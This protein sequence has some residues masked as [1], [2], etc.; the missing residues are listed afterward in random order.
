MTENDLLNKEIN[1]WACT[2]L[3]SLGYTLESD[4]PDIVLNTPWSYVVRFETSEA[5]L[6]LKHTPEPLALE[7][8]IIQ[9][10]RDQF[11]ASVPTVIA[12]NAKLNCFL[13]KDAGRP[14]R[15]LLKQQFDA[16]LL[17]KA[18]DQFTAMQFAVAERVYVFLDI[19]VPDWR[20][21]QLPDLYMEMLSQKD[22]LMADGISEI[23]IRP[24]EALHPQVSTLC[25]KLSDYGLKQTIIQPDFHDNNLLI[26]DVSQKITII[27]LGEV[28]V[29]HPFFS[30]I[31][32]LQQIKKHH[33][34]TDDDEAYLKIKEACMKSYSQF[35]LAG[36]LSIAQPLWHVYSI[37]S[38]TRLMNACGKDN[39][40]SIQPGRLS[41]SLKALRKAL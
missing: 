7:A 36:V 25:E 32:F 15:D 23:E 37:L 5:Y 28:V 20:L 10:L 9:I 33:A 13:M 31:N 35:D 22:I 2:Q 24:L 8:T 11:Q 38:Q 41:H 19:G 6:Y 1:Q 27:D 29:S 26:D 12:H 34:L 17:C 14:L 39:I 3:A 30:L 21:E 40:I 4:H 18:I 16:A